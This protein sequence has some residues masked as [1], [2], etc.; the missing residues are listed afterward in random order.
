VVYFVRTASIR[1]GKAKEALAWAAQIAT[2]VNQKHPGFNVQVL[3]NV[4]GPLNQ[5][6]WV[7]TCES[8]AAFEQ[9]FMKLQTDPSYEALVAGAPELFV[10]GSAVDNLYRTLP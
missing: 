10:E 1:A 9:I 8:L 5:I 6:H 3:H 2:Y 4:A 7:G